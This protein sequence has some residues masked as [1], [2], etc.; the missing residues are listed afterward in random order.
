[1]NVDVRGV[2][3]LFDCGEDVELTQDELDFPHLHES[4][5]YVQKPPYIQPHPLQH[6][7]KWDDTA[8]ETELYDLNLTDLGSGAFV[9]NAQTH[10]TSLR[11]NTTARYESDPQDYHLGGPRDIHPPEVLIQAG[12][13]CKVDIWA[14]GCLVCT[15]L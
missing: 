11:K 15:N 2:S 8:M 9:Y 13:D 10:V 7:W 4:K 14:V 12:Y 6:D 5:A 3:V 1:L